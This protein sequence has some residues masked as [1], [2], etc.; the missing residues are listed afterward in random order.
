[1]QRYLDGVLTPTRNG[2]RVNISVK[3]GSSIATTGV[4]VGLLLPAVQ[5]SREAARRMSAGNN[6][7][8]IMLAMHNYHAAYNHFPPAAITDKDGKPL[9]SWRVAILPLS[10]NKLSTISFI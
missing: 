10:K 2:S 4:L 7:K 3:S 6:L 5:A 1:M 9:L 8:Q